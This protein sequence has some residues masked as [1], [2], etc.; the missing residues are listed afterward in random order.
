MRLREL[1]PR[2]WTFAGETVLVGLTFDCPCCRNIRLAVQFHH[3]GREA[4]D[5][6]YILCHPARQDHTWTLIGDEDFDTI[7]IE[8]SIDASSAGHAHFHITRGAIV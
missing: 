2:W 7:T 5:D 8:P 1:N 6:Q 4:I 3:K